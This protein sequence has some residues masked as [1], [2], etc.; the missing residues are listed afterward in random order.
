M[1]GFATPPAA[2]F[3]EPF[4]MLHA[5]HERVERSLALL[6]R[7]LAHL[8]RQGAD[9]QAQDAARDVRRY[10]ERA[11]PLHHEDEE[12]HVLPV[13][14]AQGEGALADRLLADHAAMA[15]A[16][17]TLRPV[18]MAVE[19]GDAGPALDPAT[20]ALHARFVT[21]YAEHIALEE[22]SAFV[23]A[24]SALDAAAQAAMGREM[25]ARRG[26]P[27]STGPSRPA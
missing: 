13:L 1:P 17:A 27:T 6:A 9:A 25:A 16:W 22:Q 5:C 24:R 8:V 21:L 14:R 20:A 23:K 26:V 10:F 19:A 2:G 15:T 11:A 4:E 3:D 12:R 18:L 7:L